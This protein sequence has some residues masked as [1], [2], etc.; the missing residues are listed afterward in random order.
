MDNTDKQTAGPVDRLKSV[1]ALKTFAD[2]AELILTGGHRNSFWDCETAFK[3]LLA[4]GFVI[5]LLNSELDLMC[6]SNAYIPV[7]GS[8]EIDMGV[9]L[10]DNFSLWLKLLEPG[11]KLSDK[12]FSTTEDLMVALIDFQGTG[13]LKMEA[14]EQPHP[15][16]N[17]IPEKHGPLIRG[18][19]TEL[20]AGEIYRIRAAADIF[21]IVSVDKP[22][23]LLTFSSVCRVPLRWEY[24]RETW[25]PQRATASS[26]R[27]SRITYVAELLGEIGESSSVPVLLSLATHEDHYVRWAMIQNIF[28]L[29]QQEGLRLLEKALTD[30]HPH[31]RKAA[32]LSIGTIRSLNNN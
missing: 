18:N 25:L 15:F 11:M 1:P 29:D 13:A 17:N 8:S 5:D 31:I 24:S 32:R 23:L 22:V 7:G 21:R 20:Q 16:P 12:L 27:S 2:Q 26:A 3:A 4:S 28:R 10:K 19:K 6:S 30:V 9:L 14:F